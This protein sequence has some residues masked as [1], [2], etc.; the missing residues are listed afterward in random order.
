[1]KGKKIM[2]KQV[3][4]SVRNNIEIIDSIKDILKNNNIEYEDEM[5]T[6]DWYANST[7]NA[8]YTKHTD[9]I[10]TI[11]VK[12]NDLEKALKINE[13]AD[14]I[15]G[16]DQYII[17]NVDKELEENYEKVDSEEEKSD[18]EYEDAINKFG[19]LFVK[20]LLYCFYL[21]IIIIC[22]YFFRVNMINR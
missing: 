17:E 21:F 2:E 14:I 20:I 4:I 16:H 5:E 18:E 10:I 15:Y 9:Y 13:I 22:I 1:M 11:Y 6:R 12:A 8:I 7:K 3:L 19:K